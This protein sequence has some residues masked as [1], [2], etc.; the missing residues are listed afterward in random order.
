MHNISFS[1]ELFSEIPASTISRVLCITLPSDTDNVV[2]AGGSNGKL[3]R[4]QASSNQSQVVDAHEGY[5]WGLVINEE[6]TMVF[7]GSGTGYSVKVSSRRSYVVMC[8]WKI[9]G[10]FKIIP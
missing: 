4:H 10:S 7:T 2:F 1:A 9:F 3:L 5:L 6:N 8:S